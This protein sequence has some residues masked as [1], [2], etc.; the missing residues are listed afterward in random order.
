MRS[1]GSMIWLIFIH[2][3]RDLLKDK[4]TILLTIILPI[5]VYPLLM[6]GMSKMQNFQERQFETST[7]EVAVDQTGEWL[8]PFLR[9]SEQ[10]VRVVRDLDDPIEAVKSK[11]IQAYIE[12][13]GTDEPGAAL[14]VVHYNAAD[15]L[16][17]RTR[18]IL[19]DILREAK[20]AFVEKRI[21]KFGKRYRVEDVLQVEM[22]D[23]ATDR[24]KSGYLA[25]KVVP[26]LTILMILSGASF[27]AI[28]LLSGEKERGTLETL[29]LAPVSRRSI[30]IGKFLVVF[31]IATLSAIINLLGV[32]ITFAF[33][34]LDLPL[35]RGVVFSLGFGEI[36]L[37][38]LLTLPLA[39]FFSAVLMIVASY[40]D[41]FKEGQYYVLPLTFISIVP[42]LASLLP[43]IQL[44]SI[45]SIA[46][47][48]SIAV[49]SK[50]VLTGI[51]RWP[52]IALTL[53]ANTLYAAVCLRL[54]TRLLERES[55]L[56][57]TRSVVPTAEARLAKQAFY[58]FAATWLL[59]Y[60]GGSV[61][62]KDDIIIGLWLT[63]ILVVALPAL[64]FACLNRK[65]LL[66]FFALKLPNPMQ[67]LGALFLE[68]GVFLSIIPLMKLQAWFLP[69]PSS[70]MSEFGD[71]M[72]DTGYA[73]W[74]N[75]FTFAVSAGI[76]EELLFRGAI[77]KALRGKFSTIT[78]I[79]VAGTMFGLFHF[80][81]YRLLP[82][83]TI[84][85]VYTY[86]RLRTGSI[87][88]TMI[89]HAIHNGFAVGWGSA[90]GPAFERQIM[91]LP[92]I[93][94]IITLY[95][96]GWAILRT[97]STEVKDE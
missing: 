19:V 46:P 33:N 94:L 27:A 91:S 77:T 13:I 42:A 62:Q 8:T 84:G 69:A 5:T 52:W 82:T 32:S 71:A 39:V 6:F 12:M 56:P 78:V 75:I 73:G 64:V 59:L 88:P 86:I 26:L 36:S 7:L 92:G 57:G 29:L 20:G 18:R 3:L 2:E 70:F 85:F 44:N 67:M 83:A 48:A 80:N 30:I 61:F 21:S 55:I 96:L 50:E 87:L 43:G 16:S 74:I 35:L 60:F 23:L 72:L 95:F 90:L 15:E 66:D 25:G 97:A 79:L 31:I 41:T 51:Y 1:S 89:L 58:L 14:A 28:D 37:I 76:C 24:E 53:A 81:I 49:A 68:G 17:G 9:D 4:T 45:I 38:L 34:L 63:Q 54:A 47:I 11:S 65:P 10:K 22:V 93:L 40:A